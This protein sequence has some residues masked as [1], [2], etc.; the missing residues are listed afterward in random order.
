VLSI[1]KLSTVS[2]LTDHHQQFVA[3]S[4]VTIINIIVTVWVSL[5]VAVT[6]V[7]LVPLAASLIGRAI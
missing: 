5:A 6:G 7:I 1:N 2:R 3:S 4:G